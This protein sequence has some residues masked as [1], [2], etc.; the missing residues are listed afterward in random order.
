MAGQ[1]IDNNVKKIIKI[2]MM[3]RK[4]SKGL[5]RFPCPD[6]IQTSN[7]I[8]FIHYNIFVIP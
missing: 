3:I 6:A 7:N 2:R 4:Y 1:K 8:G 5:R